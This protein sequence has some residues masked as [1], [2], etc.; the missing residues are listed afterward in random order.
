MEVITFSED[1]FW[2]SDIPTYIQFL[3]IYG[4][5]VAYH[6]NKMTQLFTTRG[7]TKHDHYSYVPFTLQSFEESSREVQASLEFCLKIFMVIYI[8]NIFNYSI[9]KR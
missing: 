2:N 9:Y 6:R 7:P 4:V 3:L 8:L 1:L 5:N